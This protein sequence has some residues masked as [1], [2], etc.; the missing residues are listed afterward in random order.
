[1]LLEMKFSGVADQQEYKMLYGISQTKEQHNGKERQT[2]NE[3]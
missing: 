3:E 2:R 1:M